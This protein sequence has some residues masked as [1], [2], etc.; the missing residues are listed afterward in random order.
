MKI[1]CLAILLT[2]TFASNA[3][4]EYFQ[5]PVSWLVNV[6][7]IDEVFQ[8]NYASRYYI[9]GDSTVQS[10]LYKKCYSQQISYSYTE[11]VD[12]PYIIQDHFAGGLVFAK[13]VR[14]DNKAFYWWNDETGQDELM[15]NFDADVGEEI[16]VN[17]SLYA[18]WFVN[19]V[20]SFLLDN[21]WHKVLYATD[22]NGNQQQTFYEGIGHEF[23]FLEATGV[24]PGTV[25]DLACYSYAGVDYS[26]DPWEPFIQPSEAC[27]EILFVGEVF[28]PS[29]TR[30][31]PNPVA[32]ELTIISK[33][34]FKIF[35]VFTLHGSVI[36][37][38]ILNSKRLNVSGLDNGSYILSLESDAKK[39]SVIFH[40]D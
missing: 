17:P 30:I 37:S 35:K 2:C 14:S 6:D 19:L 13:L 11:I 26:L 36:Q 4:N 15:I 8:P 10:Q 33:D 34:N 7:I 16:I 12:P 31:F 1:V 24:I 29:E 5:Q 21:T 9:L 20:D 27:S 3:Q 38:G 40:K 28:S 25:T 32:D 22:S 23:G 39:V 18:G